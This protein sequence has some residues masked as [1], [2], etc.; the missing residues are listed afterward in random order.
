MG[1]L[2]K[3]NAVLERATAEPS[4]SPGVIQTFSFNDALTGNMI[5]VSVGDRFTR[6]TINGRDYYVD[7][8]T[9]RFAGTGMG[10]C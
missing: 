8:I 2:E 4:R 6:L 5:I 10:C 1:L 9:G 7:R 3:S